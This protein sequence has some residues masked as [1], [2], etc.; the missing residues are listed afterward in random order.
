MYNKT[1]VRFVF[2]DIRKNQGLAKCCQPRPSTRLITLTSILIIPDI[3]KTE[4]NNCLTSMTL[5]FKLKDLRFGQAAG[6][7]YLV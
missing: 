4:S 2:C 6:K 5:F 3:T 7:C 1:I